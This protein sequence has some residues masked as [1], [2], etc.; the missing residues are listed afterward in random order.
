MSPPS[1]VT[2]GAGDGSTS[3]GRVIVHQGY[4]EKKSNSYRK[5]Q[6]RWFVLHTAPGGADA[7]L[8]YFESEAKAAALVSAMGSGSH[9]GAG[10]PLSPL[11]SSSSAY[12]LSNLDDSD[13]DSEDTGKDGEGA[14]GGIQLLPMAMIWRTGP[15]AGPGIPSF[16]LSSST[17]ASTAA[18]TAATTSGI[19]ITT[20]PPVNQNPEHT[21][22]IHAHGAGSGVP[23]FELDVLGRTYFFRA[24]SEMEMD[25]WISVIAPLIP[26]HPTIASIAPVHHRS[27]DVFGTADKPLVLFAELAGNLDK[28]SGTFKNW[29]SRYFVLRGYKLL[30][31]VDESLRE[32]VGSI[33][34]HDATHVSI[35]APTSNA[36]S[37]SGSKNLMPSIL[38]SVRFGRSKSGSGSGSSTSQAQ[39]LTVYT[40]NRSYPFRIPSPNSGID[41]DV[42]LSALSAAVT[43]VSRCAGERARVW[44]IT[45]DPKRRTT[46]FL[47]TISTPAHYLAAK[48][49]ASDL[50]KRSTLTGFNSI[51]ASTIGLGVSASSPIKEASSPTS[52]AKEPAV[53]ASPVVTS[54]PEPVASEPAVP[55]PAVPEPTVP[56]PEADVVFAPAVQALEPSTAEEAPATSSAAPSSD[57]TTAP[58]PIKQPT[59]PDFGRQ[60]SSDLDMLIAS[61]TPTAGAGTPPPPAIT[62][63][64]ESLRSEHTSQTIASPIPDA[65]LPTPPQSASLL[66]P[67]H[68]LGPAGSRVSFVGGAALP[69]PLSGPALTNDGASTA[70][71]L[72]QKPSSVTATSP[73]GYISV[74]PLQSLSGNGFD[75]SLIALINPGAGPALPA[76]LPAPLPP[77]LEEAQ[78][79]AES[80]DPAADPAADP[81]VDPAADPAADPDAIP[82]SED[83]S[84]LVEEPA[85]EVTVEAIPLSD[86]PTDALLSLVILQVSLRLPG[87]LF[88]GDVSSVPG[89]S[90]LEVS[91]SHMDSPAQGFFDSLAIPSHL[92]AFPR[93]ALR[94]TIPDGALVE[95]DLTLAFM[96]LWTRIA[97]DPQTFATLL[98]DH[99]TKLGEVTGAP[100]CVS[101]LT[102]VALAGYILQWPIAEPDYHTPALVA[103]TLLL[104]LLARGSLGVAD[105]RLESLLPASAFLAVLRPV[106]SF[107]PACSFQ[108][109]A[110]L[111]TPLTPAT[112]VI[113]LD[114]LL[115][116]D[117]SD[118]GAS[119]L[120]ELYPSVTGADFARSTV[121]CFQAT[122]TS[123]RRFTGVAAAIEALGAISALRLLRALL[124]H[125]SD[126]GEIRA[127]STGLGQQLSPS[128]LS[129]WWLEPSD[130]L[131]APAGADEEDDEEGAPCLQEALASSL[132]AGLP[133]LFG[134]F[135]SPTACILAT[136]DLFDPPSAFGKFG[137]ELVA[138]IIR[139]LF[140]GD[141]VLSGDVAMDD[142]CA[143]LEA[144]LRA[145]V[146]LLT[147]FP[148]GASPGDN[149][150]S[151]LFGAMSKPATGSDPSSDPMSARRKWA[152]EAVS[153]TR[154][155][156]APVLVAGALQIGGAT[157]SEDMDVLAAAL[158]ADTPLVHLVPSALNAI[159]RSLQRAGCLE[160][161]VDILAAPPGYCHIHDTTGELLARAT[162]ALLWFLEEELSTRELIRS[163]AAKFLVEQLAA[164]SHAGS[165]ALADS[166][167]SA[168]AN[169]T[170]AQAAN[171][172][173]Q[174][175]VAGAAVAALCRLTSAD[176]SSRQAVLRAGR[177][178]L[179][180]T[181]LSNAVAQAP[182]RL[183][184]RDPE[185]G[186]GL[187]AP[188]HFTLGQDRVPG[189]A[190]G[191]D[192]LG[193][194]FATCDTATTLYRAVELL[195]N[196]AH[197]ADPIRL[198]D[199]ADAPGILMTVLARFHGGQAVDGGGG[200]GGA[201]GP[202]DRAPAYRDEELA[203]AAAVALHNLSLDPVARASLHRDGAFG[204]LVAL[205]CLRADLLPEVGTAGATEVPKRERGV[206][207]GPSPARTVQRLL[208]R[209]LLN[210]CQ[211]PQHLVELY[212]LAAH[213]AIGRVA[214][215]ATALPNPG[216]VD[217]ELAD[218]SAVS[219]YL[220]AA[221]SAITPEDL[222][223]HADAN[224][225][226]DTQEAGDA[227][228]DDAPESGKLW[229]RL[230]Y[231]GT[232]RMATIRRPTADRPLRKA[233]LDAVARQ[234]FGSATAG[235]SAGRMVFWHCDSEGTELAIAAD[236]EAAYVSE[237]LLAGVAGSDADAR[238][239][240]SLRLAIQP[241]GAGD[242][243]DPG[244]PPPPSLEAAPQRGRLL[245]ELRLISSMASK[246]EEVA[247]GVMV[248]PTGAVT[249]AFGLKKVDHEQIARERDERRRRE[250]PVEAQ[251]QDML[252]SI[253][254]K[255]AQAGDGDLSITDAA[256]AVG[257]KLRSV[258]RHAPKPVSD[259]HESNSLMLNVEAARR[260]MAI[261]DDRYHN[262]SSSD[263]DSGEDDW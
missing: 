62:L 260:R 250:N 256:A 230:S 5:F 214:D 42:W 101:F 4:L 24:S 134:Y 130:Q 166:P 176:D 141:S 57:L 162:E 148:P 194:G 7:R 25:S 211:E 126:S 229:L 55:E 35:G 86:V 212:C 243:D 253:R 179:L 76:P 127:L 221:V 207:A 206:C 77:A 59:A 10:E 251:R 147:A 225:E 22:V 14:S 242:S 29:K 177:H 113:F 168:A 120:A 68:P 223:A 121:A 170:P 200:G 87:T 38:G 66:P 17:R 78:S 90:C 27:E 224:E 263:S 174:R 219:T 202:G 184:H 248:P 80:T 262:S 137:L 189:P 235:V 122:S 34:L 23:S 97:W 100:G 28:L 171:L 261:A 254:L 222:A 88:D 180:L 232:T 84:E 231:S 82:D 79:P 119:S 117:L 138:C 182:V 118:S 178:R 71:G 181:M 146:A 244:A 6:R 249:S 233:H 3:A 197:D 30:Y 83:A 245:D 13:S 159:R 187:W 99:S 160:P 228:L 183:A 238:L 218:I 74:D 154:V 64:V 227:D 195:G 70:A 116:I 105:S 136:K 255:A 149:F 246:G 48:A 43:R 151:W 32:P 89:G 41:A 192:S 111:A 143:A 157:A 213:G 217:E 49:T 31:Y 46:L 112:V 155:L 63:P 156:V 114:L 102:Q 191:G 104:M 215:A 124:P 247:T 98:V 50:N 53:S 106:M 259:P 96:E 199:A 93:A 140:D 58:L 69:S 204:P 198:L 241:P 110:L 40:H 133:I 145:S 129:W 257:V 109:A 51:R 54:P 193:A 108:P 65:A 169:V 196:L 172:W 81:A 131:G 9:T 236:D 239:T 61:L 60:A 190:N 95:A 188:G 75:E 44:G 208:L 167:T 216:D 209:V 185:T 73:D 234:R 132:G 144:A 210:V 72:P 175:R 36:P 8:S 47:P 11:G 205:A 165:A 161:L 1:L 226:G 158:Q 21:G 237:I 139:P 123:V 128:S 150:A 2:A 258:E 203:L 186:F 125:N 142:V 220:L 45:W 67:P 85:E 252:A 153:I 107:F 20:T 56:E 152:L 33:D 37:T 173:R 26:Q 12:N 201:E 91:S 16:K 135:A 164:C 19:A 52:P 94:Q 163:N 103:I 115:S 240:L 15:S 39:V 92:G 18:S